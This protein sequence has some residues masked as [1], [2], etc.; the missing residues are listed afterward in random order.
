MGPR[1]A[2]AQIMAMIKAGRATNDVAELHHL[3]GEMEAVV[4][5]AIG[6]RSLRK[7]RSLRPLR[8]R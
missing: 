2:L 3:L 8:N 1:E 4:H 5:A 6:R 7:A